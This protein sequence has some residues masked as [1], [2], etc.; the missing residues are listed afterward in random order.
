MTHS[1]LENINSI[2]IN[3]EDKSNFQT[4]KYDEED[5]VSDELKK[6]EN[7]TIENSSNKKEIEKKESYEY[8]IGNYLIKRTIGEGT[9]G[10]VKLGLYIPEKEIVAIKILEKKRLKG[11]EDEIRIKREFDIISKLEHPN[12][13]MVTEIF[14]NSDRFFS[15]MEYCS[16]GELFNYIVKKRYLKEK[17]ASF[18]YYQIISGLE[19]I[20]SL[21]IVHRDL[22]PENLLFT[23]DHLLKIIDFGLSN[24]FSEDNNQ[25]LTT[26]CG[27]PSYASPE[28]V[29]G[30]KYNGF[31]ID[32]WSTGIILYAMLC[33]YLPFEDKDN[34]ILFDK[35]LECKL[36]FPENISS[37]GKDL[38]KKILV[39]D[40]NQ[41]ISMNGIKNHPFYLMGKKLFDEIFTIQRVNID[42]EKGT[43]NEKDD[44]NNSQKK[45]EEI[46]KNFYSNKS[47]Q[48]SKNSILVK[49]ENNNNEKYIE[50]NENIC[51][52]KNENDIKE[53][54]KEE[55]EKSK[56]INIKN[57]RIKNKILQKKKKDKIFFSNILSSKIIKKDKVKKIKEEI[58][59]IKDKNQLDKLQKR[60]TVGYKSIGLNILENSNIINPKENITTNFMVN[61]N[62]INYNVNISL[63]DI[64]S[65][66]TDDNQLILNNKKNNKTQKNKNVNIEGFYLNNNMVKINNYFKNIKNKINKDNIHINKFKKNANLKN[67]IYTDNIKSERDSSNNFNYLLNRTKIN[68]SHKISKIS[69]LKKFGDKKN[70]NTFRIKNNLTNFIENINKM[71]IKK[72]YEATIKN[73]SKNK[74]KMKIKHHNTSNYHNIANNVINF[75][76]IL[77]KT[78]ES[79]SKHSINYNKNFI[80]SSIKTSKSKKIFRKSPKSLINKDSKNFNN[81]LQKYNNISHQS[82][83]NELNPIIIQ[84]APNMKNHKPKLKLK[85]QFKNKNKSELNSISFNSNKKIYNN[86]KIKH[87]NKYNYHS[88]RFSNYKKIHKNSL[89]PD[90]YLKR[91]NPNKDSK[92]KKERNSSNHSNP[93][94]LF[95]LSHPK[96][97]IISKKNNPPMNINNYS[98][99][100]HLKKKSNSNENNK[101]SF[102]ERKGNNKSKYINY[103]NN[104]NSNN[105]LKN[106]CKMNNT[107]KSLNNLKIIYKLMN[108]KKSKSKSKV[109]SK[110]KKNK[111][112]KNIILLK[113]NV[114]NN[115]FTYKESKTKLNYIK[116]NKK[117]NNAECNSNKKEKK[118]NNYKNYS[119]SLL[120]VIKK[121][122][123]KFNNRKM[124]LKK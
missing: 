69:L 105:I 81:K 53:N 65:L 24:Y 54:K 116:K 107:S 22:K 91:I 2:S 43:N 21:G 117:I 102:K 26:P 103:V 8:K 40:P 4:I 13:I 76:N 95:S 123:F 85:S 58:N 20:H 124:E 47:N 12:V 87:K 104:Y 86:K 62:N 48:N 32:I 109:A 90:I 38:I 70:N 7:N 93:S 108:S 51:S 6:E 16:G 77:N 30:K 112:I 49:K 56:T 83:E 36:I 46:N 59:K 66:N 110:D 14:E 84:T 72:L 118:N 114:I 73:N 11:K 75:K 100:T 98:F 88:F 113:G 74:N 57:K 80:V 82:M 29:A 18:F 52:I 33:G 115:N 55:K 27:S 120:N 19:Y 64:K 121:N 122:H 1:N 67:Y 10:K 119:L 50:K 63:Q 9:F 3:E 99:T 44:K 94:S 42:C 34:D 111:T 17:E 31:K 96:R 71:K 68:I 92:L 39:V 41:R 15:V 79:F 97:R 106:L 61:N 28:M 78:N 60:N 35:I 89:S 37:S 45:S 25:L 5:L 23:K 101:E